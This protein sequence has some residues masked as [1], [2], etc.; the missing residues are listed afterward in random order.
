MAA[1]VASRQKNREFYLRLCNSEEA[2]KVP[3][4]ACIRKRVAIL[5]AMLKE[6]SPFVH[7]ML[8]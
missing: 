3:V 7:L 8:D 2:G 4:V 6:D 5:N 1:L